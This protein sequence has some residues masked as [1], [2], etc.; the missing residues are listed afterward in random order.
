MWWNLQDKLV[1]PADMAPEPLAAAYQLTQGTSLLQV[2]IETGGAVE[3]WFLPAPA[4]SAGNAA[5]T[6]VFCHGNAEIVDYH[7]AIVSG[8]HRLGCSVLLP[9]YRGYGRSAGTPSEKGIVA[10]AV[11]F[12]D[13]LIERDDI[14]ASRIVFH[15]RSLGGGVAAQLAA[16]RTPAALIL[17]STLTSVA[18]MAHTYFAPTFLARHPFRTDR[19][20]AEIDV[21]VLI[22]HGTRD[23]IIPV[24]HG[25]KLR[26]LAAG[27][28]YVEY[29]CGHNDFPGRGN[30]DAY[31]NEI[32]DF[33][34][35]A[36]VID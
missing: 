5:P 25:H 29:D 10:D 6:V 17:E 28:A 16:R 26:Q 30:H 7:D 9:E 24:V 27:A 4:A 8:Y 32:A 34:T 2:D 35:N 31:W 22:F 36:G 14:D 23:R 15:G 20:V 18:I 19:V 12:Y 1:F 13:Q 33:L 21:P 3:A 11:R